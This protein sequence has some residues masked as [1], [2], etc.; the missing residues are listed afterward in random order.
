MSTPEVVVFRD[1]SALAQ[2][3]AARLVARIAEAQAARGTASLVLT[4]G[5]I[6]IASLAALRAHADAVEWSRVELWWGDERYVE[7]SSPDRNDRAA[8]EA[9]LRWAPGVR[10]HPMPSSDSGLS[11][12]SAAAAYVDELAAAGG[13][14][15][16]P[17]LD[18][19]LLGVGPDG[20]VASLF[21][22]APALQDERPACA[23]HGS[24]KPPPTRIT[25]TM[26][27][28][29]SA[30]EVWLLASGSAKSRAIRLALSQDTGWLQVP[31]AGARG[32]LRTIAL[33]DAE[34]A[35]LLPPG[36]APVLG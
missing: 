13:R 6:G 1:A 2:G 18:V 20:H 35:Q 29:R 16:L 3:V 33:L 10:A 21:P 36:I 5:G 24:P 31:A 12:D 17:H 7:A 14:H 28:I 27:T 22:E 8:V 11:P 25:L 19:V 23:V 30:D 26:P 4:G 15:H 9:L 34:A 32:G